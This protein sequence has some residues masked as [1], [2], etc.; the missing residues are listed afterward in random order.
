[1]AQQ[2]LN[3]TYV[4]GYSM[5]PPGFPAYNPELKANQAFDL[6]AA[7]AA[8]EASGVNPA[9]VTID[10][11]SQNPAGDEGQ[12]L[13]Y[14]QQQWQTNLGIKV[15][16]VQV[17]AGVWQ[18]MRA[19]HAMQAYRGPYEYDYVDP[20]NM[21]TGLF[22][23]QPAP[24]GKSEPWGSPRH[25]W[26]SEEFDQLV[27]DAGSEADV[28]TRLA[29]YQEAEKLLS[30]DVGV[31]FLAHQVVFQIWWPWLVGMAPDKN[32]NVVFRW[33]DIS[34]FQMYIHQN[35]DELMASA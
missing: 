26:K 9:S 2:V 15:N 7:T 21:L 4:A 24:E 31:V 14:V 16:L 33:L 30:E 29:M 19:D 12:I 3:G 8:L 32:G 20:S 25:P 11:Y 17:E 6:E 27:T 10:L 22:R 13:Q 5:L 18:Q 28:E 1:M 23:S 34:R 35:V